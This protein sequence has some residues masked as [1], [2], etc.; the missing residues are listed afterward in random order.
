MFE[1]LDGRHKPRLRVLETVEEERDI[2][3]A[4]GEELVATDS[5]V[6]YIQRQ[7][8]SIRIKRK[9]EIEANNL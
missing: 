4:Q 2:L 9:I 5:G 7:K 6:R 1:S 8:E 3:T